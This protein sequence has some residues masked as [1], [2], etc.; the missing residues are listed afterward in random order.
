MYVKCISP[1]HSGSPCTGRQCMPWDRPDSL[2]YMTGYPASPLQHT[3]CW[4]SAQSPQTAVC[5]SEIHGNIERN[6]GFNLLDNTE[7]Q[8][9]IW[10]V[11]CVGIHEWKH[12]LLYTTKFPPI[13]SIFR[14]F[15]GLV[16]YQGNAEAHPCF[17][18]ITNSKKTFTAGHRT[19][20]IQEGMLM[21]SPSLTAPTHLDA[22]VTVRKNQTR[23]WASG[24]LSFSQ[25]PIQHS[26]TLCSRNAKHLWSYTW[27]VC[28][29]ETLFFSFS[30]S[31]WEAVIQTNCP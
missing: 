26:A 3:G 13:L 29:I 20:T 22:S 11:L 17:L 27:L 23:G 18:L 24:F 2:Q 7:S 21:V 8:K 28:T 10:T 31:S 6:Q 16:I 9:C 25:F 19:V 12:C 1:S 14:F 4:V 5:R 15:H 30:F